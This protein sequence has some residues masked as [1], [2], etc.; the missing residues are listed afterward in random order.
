MVA[1][2]IPGRSICLKEE[3]DFEARLLFLLGLVAGFIVGFKPRSL[4]LDFEVVICN[5]VSRTSSTEM[6]DEPFSH[7]FCRFT[8]SLA[9]G[10]L[11]CFNAYNSV[12]LVRLLLEKKEKV[13]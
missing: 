11:L 6:V 12:S 2:L 10:D 1:A 13:E 9:K 4:S 3:M 5:E 8:A 7:L